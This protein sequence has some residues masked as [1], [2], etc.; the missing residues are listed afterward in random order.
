MVAAAPRL[1]LVDQENAPSL[2]HCS[3]KREVKVSVARRLL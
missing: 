2:C 3:F 1:K